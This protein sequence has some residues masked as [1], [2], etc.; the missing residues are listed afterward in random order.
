[1][2][3]LIKKWEDVLSITNIDKEY[4]E[5]IIIYLERV[6]NPKE[7]KNTTRIASILNILSKIDLS[8]VIFVNKNICKPH[9]ISLSVSMGEIFE[10]KSINVDVT[11]MLENN[12]M[13]EQL[14]NLNGIINNYGGIIIYDIYKI[15]QCIENEPRILLTSYI[16][17]CDVLRYKKLKKIESIYGKNR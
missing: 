16:L 9:R 15:S 11:T 3:Q 6:S 8:K 13:I 5:D 12:L 4:W 1:M 2:K 14:N 17:P 7:D 10:L